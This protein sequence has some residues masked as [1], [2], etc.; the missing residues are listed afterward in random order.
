MVKAL[1][2]ASF[3]NQGGIVTD[4]HRASFVSRLISKHYKAIGSANTTIVDRMVT[5]YTDTLP[6]SIDSL[7]HLSGLVMRK[8][9]IYQYLKCME[10]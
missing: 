4:A 8:L 2:N 10:W 9:I 5:L 1:I 3:E 7:R 6:H